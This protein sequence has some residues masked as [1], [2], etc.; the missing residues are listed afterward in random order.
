MAVSTNN[1]T[2]I[3][4]VLDECHLDKSATEYLFS[5]FL[6]TCTEF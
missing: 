6:V 1:G 3:E 2:L 4:A 5:Y